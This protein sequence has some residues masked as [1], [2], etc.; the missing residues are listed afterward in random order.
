LKK[1]FIVQV[2][3]LRS[4]R[5]SLD[6]VPAVKFQSLRGAVL[7]FTYGSVPRLRGVPLDY[8]HWPLFGGPFVEAGV[9]SEQ[10]TLKHGKMRRTLDFRTLTVT[11]SVK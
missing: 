5:I 6:P 7:E 3:R 10:L 8:A 2:Q 1:G 4:F 11:D 9:D